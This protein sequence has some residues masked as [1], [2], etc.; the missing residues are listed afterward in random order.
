MTGA[1]CSGS[2]F[3]GCNCGTGTGSFGTTSQIAKTAAYLTKSEANLSC[4]VL[5]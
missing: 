5:Y 4:Q 1:S 3:A 2:G